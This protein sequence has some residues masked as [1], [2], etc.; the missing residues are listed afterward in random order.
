MVVTATDPAVWAALVGLGAFHGINPAM[1]WLLAVAMGLQERSGRAVVRALAPL[2]VGHALA[3]AA[4]IAL[5]AALGLLIPL[6]VVRYAVAVGLVGMGIYRLFRQRHPAYGRLRMGTRQ[7]AFW[8]F[9][10][11][12]A[13]GAGLMVVPF[14]LPG[15]SALSPSL[16]AEAIAQ[17]PWLSTQATA[18]HTVAYLVVTG[19]LAGLVYWRFGL[20]FLRKG[21]VNIDLV[22][23]VALLAT[24]ILTLVW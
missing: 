6:D 9:L 15:R 17:D 14:V 5:A 24:G 13:H 21:W 22:W 8:S 2:A 10:M 20:G 3:I 16:L 23:A 4:A 1:G 18:V 7:L 19:A 11:A 12:S